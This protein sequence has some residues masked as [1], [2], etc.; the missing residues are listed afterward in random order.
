[1]FS[2]LLRS[3]AWAAVVLQATAV[4][5]SIR[6]NTGDTCGAVG[7]F[8]SNPTPETWSK[9][10]TDAWLNNWWTE[11]AQNRTD[12]KYGF[13]GAFG[14]YALNDEDWSC[15]NTGD[16]NNCR[17]E[18]C[19]PDLNSLGNSTEQAYYVA[20]AISN[21]HGFWLGLEQSFGPTSGISALDTDALVLNFWHDENS[22]DALVLKE[23]LNLV[24]VVIGVAVI[25][26][27]A[28]ALAPVIGATAPVLL[29]AGSAMISGGIGAAIIGITSK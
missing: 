16:T 8:K 25:G 15:Q 21:L 12:N 26:L 6:D 3:G 1:M 18:T 27:S 14:K 17:L 10:N 20:R 19:D 11:N 28:P 5:H 23:I 4:P 2:A 13:A 22:W 29:G 7:Q 9:A 24:A